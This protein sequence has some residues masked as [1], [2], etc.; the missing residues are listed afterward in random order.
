MQSNHDFLEKM[1]GILAMYPLT[2][3]SSDDSSTLTL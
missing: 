1:Q 3:E 2:T